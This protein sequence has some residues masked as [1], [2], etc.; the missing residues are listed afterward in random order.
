MHAFMI[1]SWDLHRYSTDTSVFFF[2]LLLGFFG[3]GSSLKT[4]CKGAWR[5]CTG[6]ISPTDFR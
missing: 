5:L 2:C 4:L 3:G 1:A 6:Q